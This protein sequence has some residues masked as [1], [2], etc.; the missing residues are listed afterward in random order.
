MKPI[1]IIISIVFAL[2]LVLVLYKPA[3]AKTVVFSEDFENDLSQ[4]QEVRNMQWRNNQKKCLNQGY[5]AEPTIRNGEL[6]FTIDG[7]PCTM[8]LAATE[9]DLSP[10]DEY[11]LSFDWQFLESTAM[12]RNMVFSW[13]DQENWYG[14]KIYNNEVVLQKVVNNTAYFLEN[15]V[16][17]FPFTTNTWYHMDIVVNKVTKTITVQVDTTAILEV[18]DTPPYL[19]EGPI[20]IALQAGVGAAQ[21]THTRIDSITVTADDVLI[22]LPVTKLMQNDPLWGSQMYDSAQEWA[23]TYGN[24]HSIA[25]WGCNLTAQ[26][27]VLQFY[28]ITTLPDGT[29]LTPLSLN[30]WLLT[31][32]GYYEGTGLIKQTSVSR[33]SAVIAPEYATPKLEYS[34]TADN[35]V[36]TARA[37]IEQ[38]RPVII[39]LEGHFVVGYGLTNSGDILIHDPSYEIKQLQDHHLPVKS[40]RAYY[41]THSDL[42]SVVFSSASPFS[43]QLSTPE[44]A[45]FSQSAHNEFIQHPENTA[46]STP[47]RYSAGFFKLDPSIYQVTL[48]SS[49][50][51][52]VMV[53]ATTK[54]GQLSFT[55]TYSIQ[56]A[57]TFQVSDEKEFSILQKEG[58]GQKLKKRYYFRDFPTIGEKKGLIKHPHVLERIVNHFKKIRLHRYNSSL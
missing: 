31:D 7:P 20:T 43:V 13:Q 54:A 15:A 28:G 52:E 45:V 14:I 21:R 40:V 30:N 37:E 42:S 25:D 27:M 1:R 17:S 10:Y 5:E 19:E 32:N 33:L 46:L 56:N 11:T 8:E 18:I 39:E 22:S 41:P 3:A 9:L 26:T 50:Q 57:P 58:K 6:D 44:G 36:N 38:G 34:Y 35:P 47:V 55:D 12:D 2:V 53:E 49:S 29:P 48:E 4:W 51:D 16:T 23:E 24:K